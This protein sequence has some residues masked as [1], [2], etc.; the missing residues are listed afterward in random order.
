MNRPVT[1]PRR[2]G[3]LARPTRR[4][5]LH[6]LAAGALALGGL[7]LRAAGTA[8]DLFEGDPY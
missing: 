2:T 3:T 8:D 7:P 4:Q 6:L 5:G 1:G